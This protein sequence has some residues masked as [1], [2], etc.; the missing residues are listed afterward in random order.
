MPRAYRGAMAIHIKQNPRAAILDFHR[1]N[2]RV[3]TNSFVGTH[4]IIALSR[5]TSFRFPHWRSA[6]EGAPNVGARW[7]HSART[8]SHLLGGSPESVLGRTFENAIW[9]FASRL[10]AP[11]AHVCQEISRSGRQSVGTRNDARLAQEIRRHRG[12]SVV[13]CLQE[14]SGVTNSPRLVAF[15][16][17][18]GGGYAHSH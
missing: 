17:T 14:T 11:V 12:Q 7:R 2:H 16:Q 13:T 4:S 5:G 6:W 8:M 10:A 3:G 15:T 9:C 18:E 1:E